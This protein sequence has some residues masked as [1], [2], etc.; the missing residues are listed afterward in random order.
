MTVRWRNNS[1]TDTE[2]NYVLSLVKDKYNSRSI[3][4]MKLPIEIEKCTIISIE[5]LL[6]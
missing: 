3:N 6:Q 2:V 4:V 1:K 5:R